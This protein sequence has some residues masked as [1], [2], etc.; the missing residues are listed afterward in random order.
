[1]DETCS[2]SFAAPTARQPTREEP[3][4]DFCIVTSSNTPGGTHDELLLIDALEQLGYSARTSVWNDPE[5]DWA[6]GRVSVIRSTWDYHRHFGDWS[7]WLSRVS[8][9]TRLINE[10][11]LLRWNSS[12]DYLRDLASRGVPCVPT[13]FLSRAAGVSLESIARQRNWSKLIVKPAVGASAFG[14]R[15]F[16]APSFAGDGQRYL[17]QLLQEGTV[18]V[19]P[20]LTAVEDTQ[21]RS[22]VFIEAEFSHAFTKPPFSSS[23]Y[24]N[25]GVRRHDPTPAE[26]AIARS[27]IAAAPGGPVYARIDLIDGGEGPWLMELELVEPDLGLRFRPKAPAKLAEALQRCF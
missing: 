7:R 25:N 1:M 3:Q 23:L 11:G 12:K 19:Q 8:A 16:G 9:L 21:E 26:L 22:L 13:E 17:E 27:A 10:P 20:Y 14:V 18:L 15:T 24:G 6:D 4:V 5:A 2:G